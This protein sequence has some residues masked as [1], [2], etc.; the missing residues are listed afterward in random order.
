MSER[1]YS[2]LFWTL[3]LV[4]L[5]FDLGS[6]YA[7]F[8]WLY[9][10]NLEGKR[11]LIPGAFQLVAHY[12]PEGKPHVNPGALFGLGGQKETTAHRFF[13]W[14]GEKLGGIDGVTASNGF[15]AVV[16]LAAA[17]AI[18]IWSTRP[19]AS[20]DRILSAALGLILG[21]TVG[22]LYD[23]IV[24]SGVRDFLDF[25]LI[26]WPVFNIADCCLVCGAF[27]LL[28][29]AFWAPPVPVAQAQA[30]VGLSSK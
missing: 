3:A 11:T 24:F 30:E 8:A 2:R 14:V 6:K 19:S 21:G 16:S 5:V 4:G 13:T 22:N 28:V 15:F 7:V 27:L 17:V 20:R 23:R 9:D 18:I 1:S 25:Y 10:G 29:Q 26:R 12:T